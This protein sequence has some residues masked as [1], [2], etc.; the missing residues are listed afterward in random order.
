MTGAPSL[1]EL[2]VKIFADGADLDG[3]REMSADS[4]IKGFT[5]NPTLMRRAGDC[6][7]SS[8]KA[9]VW[10]VMWPV[11]REGRTQAQ[12][13]KPQGP[14]TESRRRGVAPLSPPPFPPAATVSSA[15][16]E[17]PDPTVSSG[18]FVRLRAIFFFC[19]RLC[20]LYRLFEFPF[21]SLELASNQ[22][23]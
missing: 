14:K 20:R 4:L 7:L 16:A 11:Q 21:E 2:K 9:V 12:R 23:P 15:R 19:F 18:G 10:S 1:S 6:I 17:P 5:T 3:I 22:V 8:V 13:G